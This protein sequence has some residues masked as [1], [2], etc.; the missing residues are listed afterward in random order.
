MTNRRFTAALRFLGAGLLG[1][2]ALAGSDAR[3]VDVVGATSARL[4]W[5]S[6]TGPVAGYGVFVSKNGA[7]FPAS[8]T[9]TTTGTSA[10]VSAAYNDTVVVRVA[11]FDSAGSY[12]P[13]SPNS[14]SIRFVQGTGG[15]TPVITLSTSS[16]SS[17]TVQGASPANGSFTVRNTGTGTLSYSVADN[18]SWLS[19]TPASGSATTET[20]TISLVYSTAGLAAGS[21]S[22]TVTVSGGSG[23]TSKTL[24][25]GLTVTAVA[26]PASITLSKTSMTA[27]ALQGAS[28]AAQSFTVKNGG[29]GTLS[30]SASDSASWLALSPTSGSS[31]GEADTVTAT[32]ATTGLAAGTYSATIS[33]AGTG[34]TSKTISVSLTITK[35]PSITLSKTSIAASAVPGASPAAQSFT[36]KNGGGGT[37]SWSVSDNQ[38]WLSLSPTSGSSTGENDTVTVSFSTAGLAAGTHSATITVAGTGVASKTISVSVTIAT[39][40]SIT[41]STTSIT[42]STREKTNATGQSFTIKNGGTGTLAWTASEAASW[43]SIS[44]TSGSSKGELDTVRLA[45][46][47]ASLAPGSYSATITVAGGSGVASKTV[48]VSLTITAP[49][50]PVIS[51]STSALTASASQGQTPAAQ[52]FQVRNAGTGTLSWSASDNAS[53]LSVSPASG[54]S[55]GEY[56][57][58][59]VTFSTGSLPLGTHQASVVVNGGSGVTSMSL[60]VTLVIGSVDTGAAAVMVGFGPSGQGKLETRQAVAPVAN[61]GELVLDWAGY[62]ASVGETRPVACDV[63]GDGLDEYV[64]GTGEQGDGRLQVRDDRKAGFAHLGWLQMGVSPWASAVGET[65]P[66]CGDLDGDGKDEVV[67]GGGAGSGGVMQIFDDAGT[68]FAAFPNTPLSGGHL[69][70]AWATEAGRSGETHPAVGDLDG[71]GRGE[72]VI[73]FPNGGRIHVLDDVR[74]GFAPMSGPSTAGWI[75]IPWDAYNKIDGS[76]WP[77][78]GDIDGDGYD[79]IVVGFGNQAHGWMIVFDDRTKGFRL[80]PRG[81]NRTGWIRVKDMVYNKGKAAPTRPALGNVDGDGAEEVVVGLGPAARGKIQILDDASR[82]MS[83]LRGTPLAGGLVPLDSSAADTSTGVTWPTVGDN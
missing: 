26:A 43:L 53:W 17:T 44:P 45:F 35:A 82:Y 40:A 74:T 24:T 31:T 75:P 49:P 27:S 36:V 55:T 76:T 10:T 83:G 57:A 6:A 70:I 33:V 65:Y 4:V 41:L 60:P 12:G 7:A 1:L 32:F 66:A 42:S 28:P 34:V 16:V 39:G 21:Y 2:A 18:Q 77:A 52:T 8:P 62:A 46:S 48:A 51:L 63:D 67:V 73:G 50:K 30:W 68:G 61:L 22:A 37:L 79:E 64:V 3:A 59:S 56:D 14:D 19:V 25:V 29:G 54:S 11:A 9:L 72:L 5:S 47:T 23:V 15:G 71:D 78:S 58:I 81:K 38:S 69:V 80:Q 13:A 20:D